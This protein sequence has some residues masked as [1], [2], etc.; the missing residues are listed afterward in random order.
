MND[1]SVGT[2]F[3]YA[4]EFSKIKRTPS[5][6]FQPSPGQPDQRYRN[7]PPSHNSAES[8]GS[9]QFWVERVLIPLRFRSWNFGIGCLAPSSSAGFPARCPALRWQQRESYGHAS[10]KSNVQVSGLPSG[11]MQLGRLRSSGSSRYPTDDPAVTPGTSPPIRRLSPPTRRRQPACRG[12]SPGTCR[13]AGRPRRGH[14]RD[15]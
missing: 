4:V 5:K 13:A 6:A 9:L 10:G 14:G 7:L 15:R 3:R 1:K 2:D 11:S 8:S 12:A